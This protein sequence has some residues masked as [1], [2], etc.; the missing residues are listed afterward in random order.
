M[1]DWGGVGWWGGN[2]PCSG[3]SSKCQKQGGLGSQ[4][5]CGQFQIKSSYVREWL[6]HARMSPGLSLV[7]LAS[8]PLMGTQGG[9]R[10]APQIV[11]HAPLCTLHPYPLTSFRA[12]LL[13]Y[14]RPPFWQLLPLP[15]TLNPFLLCTGRVMETGGGRSHPTP[16]P[17]ALKTVEG[18]ESHDHAPGRSAA[19]RKAPSPPVPPSDSPGALHLSPSIQT[20][21][22]SMGPSITS[23]LTLLSPQP[24]ALSPAVMPSPLF[25]LLLSV[26]H[27][28]LLTPN[29][30]IAR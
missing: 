9:R 22:P 4:D 11:P 8:E 20:Q 18:P 16:S 17:V 12:S 27:L 5:T 24:P 19:T 29:C 28:S 3:R 26:S 14:S 6:L 2:V 21:G 1:T 30:P 13:P 10:Q 25:C 23:L 15:C 7:P